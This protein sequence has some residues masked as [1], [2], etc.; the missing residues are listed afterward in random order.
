MKKSLI[1]LSL[2]L[3]ISTNCFAGK[4]DCPAPSQITVFKL[5]E[6]SMFS[7]SWLAA[8]A[9]PTSKGF[10]LMGTAIGLGTSATVGNFDS[11]SPETI[12][13]NGVPTPGYSCTYIRMG[14]GPVTQDLMKEIDRLPENQRRKA[15]KLAQ[16]GISFSFATVEYLLK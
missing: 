15:Q 13:V 4:Y 9:M 12:I 3:A 16:Q 2:V 14:N 5:I 7:W 1:V 8:P 6:D 11:A 10:S